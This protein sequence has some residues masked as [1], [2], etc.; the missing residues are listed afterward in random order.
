[1]RKRSLIAVLLFVVPLFAQTANLKVPDADTLVG[2]PKGQPL[3][4]DELTRTTQD[5]ASSIRCPVC[6]GLSIADSPA[7]MAQNMRAQVRELLSRGYTREQI[8]SYF[9]RSYGQFVLL[10]PKFQGVTSLVW[11]LPIFAL[12]LGIVIVFMKMKSL[13]KAPPP[14]VEEVDD[15]Y[16]AR[17]RDLVKGDSQ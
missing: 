17:V 13:E 16:L 14:T 6:Q 10:K 5:L 9:E 8:L 12:I 7:E 1:M 15:P 2:P 3:A 11:T 4:G